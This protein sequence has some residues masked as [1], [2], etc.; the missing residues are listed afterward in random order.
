MSNLSP[1][2]IVCAANRYV[3]ANET[4]LLIGA[5]HWDAHM[6][7]MIPYLPKS[8]HPH[9]V[10]WEQGFIDQHENFLT[11]TEAWKIAEANGQINRRVGG[12]ER[13]GGTLYSEN[14]Y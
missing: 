1:S 11:R 13:D 9:A 14:L 2:R 6:R 5:R 3:G 4:Y 7:R 10:D 8:V 12:D